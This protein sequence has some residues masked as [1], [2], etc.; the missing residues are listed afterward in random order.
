L[1]TDFSLIFLLAALGL[2]TVAPILVGLL[3][4]HARA[5]KASEPVAGAV[6]VEEGAALWREQRAALD[7]EKA[8]GIIDAAEHGEALAALA[9]AA[10]SDLASPA[11]AT[12]QKES[13]ARSRRFWLAGLLAVLVMG[14]SIPLYFMLGRPDARKELSE[15][16]LQTSQQPQQVDPQ[17]LAMVQS[18]AKK[19]ADHPEDPTGWRLLGRSYMVIG[20]FT[21]AASAYTHVLVLD[22]TDAQS[23]VD[24]ADARAMQEGGSLSGEPMRLIAKALSID[25]KNPKGLELEGTAALQRNDA[26]AARVAWRQLRAVLPPGSPDVAQLDQALAQLDQVIEGRTGQGAP[27]GPAAAEPPGAPAPLPAAAGTTVSGL[28]DIAP[29]LAGQVSIA[30][31]VYIDARPKNPAPGASRMPLAAMRLEARQLP[32]SFTLTDGMAM[33]PAHKISDFKDLIIEAHVAKHGT[34]ITSSGDLAAIPVTAHLGDDKI[35]LVID[36]VVP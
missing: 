8:L 17:V 6:P 7:E 16:S 30:D 34:P 4:T 18:L 14:I 22:P 23:M 21:N 32:A 26:R 27:L 2:A 11:A 29:A 13:M 33:D 35:H 31:V 24:L 25:P 9:Q 36:H 3:R 15:V 28:L 20:D 1:T 12:Q 19:M 10:K 5:P